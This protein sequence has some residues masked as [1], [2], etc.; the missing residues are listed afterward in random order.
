MGFSFTVTQGLL[1]RELLVAFFGNELSIGLILGCWLILEAIGSGLLGRL[2]DRWAKRPAS[3]AAL[4]VLFA[5][6]LPLSLYA[7]YASRSLVGAIPGEGVGLVPIF[8][9]SFLILAPVAMVDGAMFAFGARAYAQLT[10]AEAPS[11]GWVYVAEAVGGLVGGIVF[12]F[13]LIPFLYSLQIVL[14]LAALNLLAAA[15]IVAGSGWSAARRL[16]LTVGLAVLLLASVAFLISPWAGKIQRW[17]IGQQWPGYDLV[18]SENSVYGN[19]AV[20]Q[21]ESQYTFY[22]DGIPILT[23]PVP[24]VAAVEEIVHL[25][26]LFVPQPRRVLVLSGGVGGVLAEL[27]KYPLERIDY[28]ELDPLLIRAVQQFP[29]PLTVSELGDPRLQI[30][31]VDGRLLVR[32]RQQALVSPQAG[33]DLVIVNLPYPSTLQLNRFYTL[34]FFELVRA[35]LAEEGV[36]VLSTPGTLSYM[37]AEMRD[38]N[39]MAYHTLGNVF[40][41]VRPI[42]GDL[43]LWLA[44]PSGDLLTVPVEALVKRW[45]ERDL[46]TALLTPAHIRLRLEQRYLDWFWS[47]LGLEG[48]PGRDVGL[49]KEREGRQGWF[50]TSASA[51]INQDLRPVG[52]FYGLSYWN[53]LFSPGLARLLGTVGR[54]NLWIL[55][56][57]IVV[58]VLLFLAVV[59]LTGK[60][61]GGVVPII[62]GATGL[63]GMTADLIIIF[64]FQSLYGYVYH[65]VALFITA[66]MAGLALG[67]LLMN[68]RLELASSPPSSDQVLT[69]HAQ[70]S[71][72]QR[73]GRRGAR[74]TLLMLEVA[75]VVFWIL[76]PVVLSVL[77]G[78]LA[79]PLMATST[80]VVLFLLNAVA[81]FLVGAQFPLANKIWLTGRES[82][83]GTTGVLYASD[84]VGAFLGAVLVSVLLLPVLGIVQ[85]CIL[86]AVLKL[87]SLVLA[88]ALIRRA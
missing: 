65:W 82:Q 63:A 29:T 78:Q 77:Y 38:L 69:G 33:Y 56:L 9:A 27:A 72:V 49:G 39:A 83:R 41:S 13:L 75:Q 76:L 42:P 71:G 37:S 57:P 64:A 61:R 4:Q 79:Q 87:G 5:L 22:A 24:D 2:A 16:A 53:A 32:Q 15:L 55:C 58:F 30:E 18:Y 68:R 52:L 8:W 66:F 60:G 36:I 88:A 14:V 34:E 70:D 73:W 25:P 31:H 26:M 48:G 7:A 20:V 1:I 43:T 35:L 51:Y 84:L 17:A 47:S 44:S 10:G 86:V 50:S 6:L 21:R 11:I 74:F 12:T 28:A 3:F 54:L 85:T 40:A 46:G 59:K 19:V 67:G 45:E 62:I 80:Q 81:G 23:A